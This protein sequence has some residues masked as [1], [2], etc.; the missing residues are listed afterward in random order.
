VEVNIEK[1]KRIKSPLPKR[2]PDK[3]GKKTKKQNKAK[4]RF[5]S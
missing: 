3:K 5:P 4:P 1:K 2:K